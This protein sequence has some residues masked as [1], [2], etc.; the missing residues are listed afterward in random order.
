M[1]HGTPA[2]KSSYSH[3]DRVF[4]RWVT[5]LG[6]QFQCVGGNKQ[7]TRLSPSYSRGT[8]QRL[9]D[10][11]PST[12]RWDFLCIHFSSSLTSG[13]R[14]LQ[15]PMD[16]FDTVSF[17][18]TC[19]WDAIGCIL[20][21]WVSLDHLYSRLKSIFVRN[22]CSVG[23]GEGRRAQPGLH[24]AQLMWVSPWFSLHWF[25]SWVWLPKSSRDGPATKTQVQSGCGDRG[26]A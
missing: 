4:E 15:C 16:S 2:H 13:P 6:A 10:L 22:L 7:K 17:S 18:H 3:A 12:G 24:F 14:T 21:L 9:G 20:H 19:R 26:G 23:K 25:S 11:K 1:P 5:G 8:M